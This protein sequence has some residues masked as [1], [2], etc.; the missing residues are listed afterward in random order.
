MAETVPWISR[1]ALAAGPRSVDDNGGEMIDIEHIINLGRPKLIADDGCLMAS[2]IYVAEIRTV[3]EGTL[4]Q[5]GAAGNDYRP[6]ISVATKSVEGNLL[7]LIYK[8]IIVNHIGHLNGRIRLIGKARR[9][10]PPPPHDS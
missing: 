6:Q 8:A 2:D 1:I 5:M 9:G 10:L 4:H 7:H 3:L